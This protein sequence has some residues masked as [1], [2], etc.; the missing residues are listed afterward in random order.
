MDELYMDED[1]RKENYLRVEISECTEKLNERQD[2][3]NFC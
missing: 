2:S 3:T 1:G